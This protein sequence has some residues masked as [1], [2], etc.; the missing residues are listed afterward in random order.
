[1]GLTVHLKPELRQ[2]RDRSYSVSVNPDR[3]LFCVFTLLPYFSLC[4]QLERCATSIGANIHESNYAQSKSDFISKLEIALK[5]SYEADYWL[6]LL[7]R[8]NLAS[9]EAVRSLKN[10]CGVIRRLLIS[11]ITTTKQNRD[12]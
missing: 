12:S 6:E 3:V 5:E 7:S 10:Q 9:P 1:M 8:A 11:S 2:S 4:N